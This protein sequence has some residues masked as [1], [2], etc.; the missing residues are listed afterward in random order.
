MR[1]LASSDNRRRF[2]A[3]SRAS[4]ASS[5]HARLPAGVMKAGQMERSRRT[6][7]SLMP[8]TSPPISACHSPESEAGRRTGSMAQRTRPS[9]RG[10]AASGN[11]LRLS[12]YSGA[13]PSVS[14]H[15]S[16]GPKV[17]PDDS[18]MTGSRCARALAA[19]A[20]D[21]PDRHA[22]RPERTARRTAV[23]TPLRDMACSSLS[24]SPVLLTDLAAAPPAQR[25]AGD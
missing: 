8:A 12:A 10:H 3:R 9:A 15:S 11:A 7:G 1:A 20:A 17:A 19:P 16:Q 21:P 24:E 23:V 6:D 25:Q 22:S 4:A 5:H 18:A 2:K 13:N 14:G